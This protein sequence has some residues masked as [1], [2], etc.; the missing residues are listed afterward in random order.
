MIRLPARKTAEA[1]PPAAPEPMTTPVEEPLVEG[2][3]TA[4]TE[5]IRTSAD[6]LKG[7][8]DFVGPNAKPVACAFCGQLYYL[9][10]KGGEHAGC[11]NFQ[12]KQRKKT[13]EPA[14]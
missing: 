11:M 9:P 6:I 14:A 13:K 7:W 4:K 1:T 8:R 12:A 2:A 10:C 3:L 5:K